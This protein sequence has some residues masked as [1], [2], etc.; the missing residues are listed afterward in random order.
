M[1]SAVGARAGEG[2]D[3]AGAGGSPAFT[4]GA[5]VHAREAGA[6]PG[7]CINASAL[8]DAAPAGKRCSPARLAHDVPGWGA[9]TLRDPKLPHP[10]GD[11][12][13]SFWNQGGWKDGR[14]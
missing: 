7:R 2:G 14:S 6:A 5:A 11:T 4:P 9:V 8:V 1:G 3:H 13:G 12:E 10:S